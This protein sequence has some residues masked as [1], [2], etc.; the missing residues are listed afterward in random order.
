MLSVQKNSMS[1]G[2]ADQ[3]MVQKPYNI[4]FDLEEYGDES[5]RGKVKNEF[6]SANECGPI[7]CSEAGR[8][9]A[10]LGSI[11]LSRKSNSKNYHLAT[12]ADLKRKT[13]STGNGNILKLQAKIFSFSTKYS[14]IIGAISDT[15]NQIIYETTVKNKTLSQPLFSRLFSPFKYPAT[16]NNN[17]SP[18]RKRRQLSDIQITENK[19]TAVYGNILPNEC[20]GHFADYPALP[21]AIVGNTLGELAIALFLFHNS[22]YSKAIVLACKINAYRLAFHGEYLTMRG[23]VK[24]KNEGRSMWVFCEAMVNSN[25]MAAAEIEVAGVENSDN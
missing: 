6:L 2:L 7:S 24:S 21:V 8:H 1:K 20:E 13:R 17:T 12:Y 25:V 10:I 9:I 14:E 11:A 5:I 3:I 4:I 23:E 22:A 15:N 16:I 18:Y 19:V